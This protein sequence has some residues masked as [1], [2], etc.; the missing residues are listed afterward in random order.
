VL[1]NS[2]FTTAQYWT[3]T[4][5]KLIP[6]VLSLRIY[7]NLCLV[8]ILS[9][10]VSRFLTFSTSFKI[11]EEMNVRITHLCSSCYV[12]SPWQ[13]PWRY[14]VYHLMLVVSWCTTSCNIKICALYPHSLFIRFVWISELW[15]KISLQQY[16]FRVYNRNIRRLLLGTK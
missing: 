7:W 6:F 4:K 5:A 1:T 13:C 10:S 2:E 11:S 12:R 15:A 8:L 16:L 3:L 14:Q 9:P